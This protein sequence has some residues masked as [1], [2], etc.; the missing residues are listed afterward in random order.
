MELLPD[1]AKSG[2][3]HLSIFISDGTKKTYDLTGFRSDFL[4]KILEDDLY[5]GYYL[6]LIQDMYFR[7]FMYN[8]YHW[9]PLPPGNVERLHNDYA[10]I[11]QYVIHKYALSNTITI[12]SSFNEEPLNKLGYFSIDEFLADLKNDFQIRLTGT[13]F[14]FSREMADEFIAYACEKCEQEIYSLLNG[15]DCIDER[16]LAW[17]KR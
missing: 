5:L 4:S 13:T 10:L 3:S 15:L 11:N 14:F 12:P 17:Q 6:H 2:N 1:A 8:R 9:N 16:A 7:D